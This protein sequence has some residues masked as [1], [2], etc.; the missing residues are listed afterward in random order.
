M[1]ESVKGGS[2]RLVILRGGGGGL[3]RKFEKFDMLIDLLD[4]RTPVGS[5]SSFFWGVL[6]LELLPIRAV[7]QAGAHSA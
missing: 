3:T 1:L 5:A 6:I 2:P 4:V 7:G